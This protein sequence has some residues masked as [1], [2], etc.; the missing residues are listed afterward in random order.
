MQV[1]TSFGMI[2]NRKVIFLSFGTK[3][4]LIR[5]R[6][7][8]DKLSLKQASVTMILLFKM[9]DITNLITELGGD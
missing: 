4:P 8:G 5:A 6:E 7:S 1:S 9:T 3:Y 2:A